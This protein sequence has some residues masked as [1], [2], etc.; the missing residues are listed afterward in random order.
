MLDVVYDGVDPLRVDAGNR[1]RGRGLMGVSDDRPIL[2]CIANLN[3]GKGHTYLLQAMPHILRASPPRAA[4]RLRR[5]TGR[6]E[7]DEASGTNSESIS[8]LL[9]LGHRHDIQDLIQAADLFAMPSLNEG[10]CSTLID[11]MFAGVPIVS[12]SAGGHPRAA[13]ARRERDSSRVDGR[14]RGRRC[15]GIGH[16][17]ATGQ[18]AGGT[19]SSRPGSQFFIRAVYGRRD[20]RRYDRSLSIGLRRSATA[21]CGLTGDGGPAN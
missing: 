1:R 6:R 21:A 20:G 12:T 11:V 18:S 9:W 7:V 17:H 19:R 14:T 2:L 4:R 13:P 16:H 15:L 8:P 5:R 10:L 3:P